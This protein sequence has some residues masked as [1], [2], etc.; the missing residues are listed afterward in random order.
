VLIFNDEDFFPCGGWHSWWEPTRAM[1][2]CQ[3]MQERRS[4]GQLC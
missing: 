2:L 3:D 4:P 1:A